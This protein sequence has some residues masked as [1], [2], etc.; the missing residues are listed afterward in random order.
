MRTL[1]CDLFDVHAALGRNHDDRHFQLPIEHHG[2]VVLLLQGQ[3]LFDEHGLHDRAVGT[4]LLGDQRL[5]QQRLGDLRGLLGAVDELDATGLA[6]PAGV[7]LCLDDGKVTAQLLEG[8]RSGLRLLHDDAFGHRQPSACEALLGL[9]F[10]QFHA[11]SPRRRADPTPPASQAHTERRTTP[12]FHPSCAWRLTQDSP[13]RSVTQA[14]PTERRAHPHQ[15]SRPRNAA[16]RGTQSPPHCDRIVGAKAAQ[17]RPLDPPTS[18]AYG[19]PPYAGRKAHPHAIGSLGRRPPQSRPLD[20]STLAPTNRGPT[21]DAK[22]A[23]LRSDRWGEGRAKP[24][25]T[26]ACGAEGTKDQAGVGPENRAVQ[27]V[28][29]GG[30]G[31]QR[32]FRRSPAEHPTVRPSRS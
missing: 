18:R 25:T 7:D 16:I 12:R 19:T 14:S 17:D 11:R 5:A 20:P 10:V 32:P 28:T 6:A 9:E 4:V 2:R 15:R 21:R 8:L 31:A 3:A 23:P 27:R 26:L 22:P 30:E 13:S 24:A 1:G 29:R